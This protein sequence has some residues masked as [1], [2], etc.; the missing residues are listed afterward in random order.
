MKITLKQKRDIIF[1]NL[2]SERSFSEQKED[3]E[4]YLSGM[5]SF[6]KGN[7]MKFAYEGIELSYEE[8]LSL[9]EIADNAFGEEVEFIY[10][11][12]PSRS[13]YRHLVGNGERLVKKITGTVRAGER[14]RSNGDIV[15]IGDVNPTATLEANGDIYVIGTLRGSAH[16]G[17]NGDENAVVYA[18]RMNPE[19]LAIGVYVGYNSQSENCVENA[20]A[21]A[22]NGVIKVKLM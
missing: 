11:T 22:E 18:M 12:Y 5:K 4:K 2:D 16:A 1:L 10:K 15:V 20:L 7:S 3:I 8:E 13:V 9:C 14:I 6:L 21:V 17:F 19:T